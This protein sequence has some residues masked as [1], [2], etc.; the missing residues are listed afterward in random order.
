MIP[1]GFPKG[2]LI[3]I[4]PKGQVEGSIH[5]IWLSLA[6]YQVSYGMVALFIDFP[7]NRSQIINDGFFPKSWRQLV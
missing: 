3:H 6:N 2:A 4:S 1:V 7:S 5:A